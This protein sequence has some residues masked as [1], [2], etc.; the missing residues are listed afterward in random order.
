L[1]DYELH[2]IEKGHKE[3]SYNNTLWKAFAK[4]LINIKTTDHAHKHG[5]ENK[6]TIED[7]E[8]GGYFE[9]KKYN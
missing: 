2:F 6:N 7:V 9:N 8:K 1:I 3:P 5:N 4:Y